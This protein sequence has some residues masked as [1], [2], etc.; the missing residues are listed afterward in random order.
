M[1][2]VRWVRCG[3]AEGG[4]KNARE[5]RNGCSVEGRSKKKDEDIYDGWTLE[6]WGGGIQESKENLH[7]C[8]VEGRRGGG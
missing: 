2:W 3:G 6:E 8:A 4:V 1:L 5:T 7:G